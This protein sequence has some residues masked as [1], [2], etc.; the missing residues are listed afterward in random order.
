MDLERRMAAVRAFLDELGIGSGAGVETPEYRQALHREIAA[1]TGRPI[2]PADLSDP[3]GKAMVDL[4]FTNPAIAGKFLAADRPRL[5][6]LLMTVT[7]L[8]GFP[9]Y[10]EQAA[11]VGGGP[12]IVCLWL[13]QRYPEARFT[14]FDRSDKALSVGRTW[15]R[16]LG[17]A[18]V[19][20]QKASY[21]DLAGSSTPERF[22]LVL[23]LGAL[24]LLLSPG[25]GRPH[26]CA[27]VDPSSFTGREPLNDFVAACRRLL[28]PE[29][30]LY[31]SQGSFSDLGLLGLFDALRSQ[32]LGVDWRYSHAVGDGEAAAFSIKALHLFARTD[33]PTVFCDARD[34]LAVLLYAAKNPRFSDK[35]VLGHGDFEAWL[36]LLSDGIKLA[37]IRARQADGRIE[38]F[39]L[40][41]KSGVLGFFS[42]HSGGGRSGFIHS[43]AAYESTV[44]RLRDIVDHYRKQ[45]VTLDSIAWHPAV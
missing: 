35:I 13:A 45:N 43:A 6:Q 22:D 24:N 15:A 31:F 23:G 25:D 11:D 29:G 39:T 44:A 33:R 30:L 7:D 9:R 4:F 20:Y 32:G 10:I 5:T 36:G 18:N 3:M 41:V 40:Y 42:S 12:G 38:R 27:A 34:D 26:L 21:A 19:H 37:D 14:V 16:T 2:G 17:L 8:P 28:S 1:V